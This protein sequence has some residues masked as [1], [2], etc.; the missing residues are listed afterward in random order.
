MADRK[1]VRGK[2]R[3]GVPSSIPSVVPTSGTRRFDLTGGSSRCGP[4]PE[5]A[6]QPLR[7][8]LQRGSFRGDDVV[9]RAKGGQPGRPSG[10]K[11]STRTRQ[12]RALQRPD[13]GRPAILGIS[14]SNMTSLGNYL[15]LVWL[16]VEFFF[17]KFVNFS[18]SFQICKNCSFD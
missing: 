9:D 11:F 7:D 16:A 18:C 6:N 17:N 13:F 5:E 8:T 14:F 12:R 15:P 1:T 2:G 3:T 4:V 10:F